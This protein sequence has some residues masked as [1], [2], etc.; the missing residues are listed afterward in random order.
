MTDSFAEHVDSQVT[1]ESIPLVQN[2]DTVADQTQSD[3]NLHPQGTGTFYRHSNPAN[4][5]RNPFRHLLRGE[6]SGNAEI[7]VGPSG[8]AE[9]IG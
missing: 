5:R 7:E 1:T 8:V 6:N 9:R 4:H 2:F 3:V